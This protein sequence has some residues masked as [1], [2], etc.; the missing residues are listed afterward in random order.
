MSRAAQRIGPAGL[1]RPGRPTI[2]PGATLRFRVCILI[3]NFPTARRARLNVY[4]AG[5]GSTRGA[6]LRMSWRAL[7]ARAGRAT[8]HCRARRISI[9]FARM[10]TRILA[11]VGCVSSAFCANW[12]GW[13]GDNGLGVTF[14]ANLPLKWSATENVLWK[15]PLPERGNST[16]AVWKDKIFLTQAVG[17][18][19]TL[20]CLDRK[21]GKTLWQS[22]TSYREEEET[23]ETNPYCSSSPAT[24][25]ERVIAWFGS[26]GV[27]C[28]DMAGK[29]F[30]RVDLGKQAHIW[31]YASSPLIHDDLCIMYFGPGKGAFLT[32]LD[33]KT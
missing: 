22:G 27:F 16:P 5:C 15:V 19:R 29:E 30:W 6:G 14:E 31:G 11:L 10:F 25:G 13:R 17:E 3:R 12:A 7:P 26:A 8:E 9:A 18:R 20:M 1:S 24:D 28:F 21:T 4:E 23:H 32:A 33:K 2:A